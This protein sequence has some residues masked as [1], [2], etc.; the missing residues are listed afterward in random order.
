MVD[1]GICLGSRFGGRQ[2]GGGM[3]GCMF[4]KGK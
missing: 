2:L 1:K 3:V 4:D